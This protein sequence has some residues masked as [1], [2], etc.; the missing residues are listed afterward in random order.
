MKKQVYLF[1]ENRR[2]ST[3]GIGTYIRQMI[4]C[5]TGIP[6]V[7][8]HLVHIGADV[9]HFE[10]KEM[11]GYNLYTIPQ[12][13][14]PIT[15]K[16]NFY[17][18]NICYLIRLNCNYAESSKLIFMF[19]YSHHHSL[20]Y[21][22]KE[23]FPDSYFYFTI[24]YQNWCFDLNGDVAHLKQIIHAED[25]SVLSSSEQTVYHSF[26]LDKELYQ[27]V[28][29][30]ICL[31]GFT[32]SLLNETYGISRDKL[33]LIYNGLKDERKI[34]TTK[35]RNLL[36]KRYH[37]SL[38]EQVILFVGRLDGIKGIETLILSFQV[39]L[40]R[41]WN[42][43]LVIAGEGDFSSCLT[44][45][46]TD[47]NKITFTGH[48]NKEQLYDFYQLAD[49]GVM[50]SMHEQCSYVAIEMMMFALPMVV[51]TTTG[52]KE[53]IQE[54]DFGFT[55]DMEKDNEE[56]QNELTKLITKVLKMPLWK[57]KKMKYFSRSSFEE[58][59]SVQEMQKKYL[60]LIFTE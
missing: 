18:R 24:H 46:G 4:I 29:K 34:L 54:E 28:D 25:P 59:Y 14:I 51:S 1:D 27:I 36:K 11:P 56:T 6:D 60:N 32:L 16:T 5:L 53:M 10:I 13:C 15:G 45:C 35:E 55:F 20:I 19:N 22:L 41:N 37:I 49:V 38:K 30:V 48:L 50:P 8:L 17:Q 2:G 44:K 52:L 58:K 47:W 33:M 9:N 12:F 23:S 57:Q 40:R 21:K 39:L 43:R 7:D 31:S 3:Y 26:R 42:Y